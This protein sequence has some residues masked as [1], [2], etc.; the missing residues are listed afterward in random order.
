MLV[1]PQRI[2]T[3]SA[4]PRSAAQLLSVFHH[5]TVLVQS[6]RSSL[7][8]VSSSDS[9]KSW[10]ERKIT[11]Q[12][13]ATESSSQDELIQI[14]FPISSNNNFVLKEEGMVHICFYN[15]S[16]I[17]MLSLKRAAS[18]IYMFFFTSMSC[19]LATHLMAFLRAVRRA[20]QKYFQGFSVASRD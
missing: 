13:S 1:N 9:R 15:V 14:Y 2:I 7:N 5:I 19:A 16:I 6:R 11:K 17:F 4:V 8:T 3:N 20:E 10:C 18:S 12:T